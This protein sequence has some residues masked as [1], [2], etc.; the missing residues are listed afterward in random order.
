M[1][2]R[3]IHAL[4]AALALIVPASCFAAEDL[5]LADSVQFAKG[6]VMI[7][8]EGKTVPSKRTVLLPNDIK[9]MTN[10]TYRVAG[11]KVRTLKEGEMIDKEGLLSS[12]DGS[13]APV[14]DHITMNNGKLLSVRDGDPQPLT[15]EFAFPD[16]SKIVPDGTLRSPN[17][18]VRRMLDGEWIT[19]SGRTIPS[20]D[21]ITLQ[22]GVV[23]VQKDGGK[24][25]LRPEQTMMMNDGSKAFGNGTVLLKDGTNITLTEGQVIA[26][27]GV[28]APK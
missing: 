18:R 11:G 13:V 16:G 2:I 4:W 1:N 23:V 21:T 22:E 25:K 10:G 5:Q 6:K 12:P 8:Q 19:L 3:M 20:R 26:V 15:A 24:F 9:V 27:E 28:S 14:V 17:G 7:A